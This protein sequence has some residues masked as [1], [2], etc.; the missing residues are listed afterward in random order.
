MR[1]S[2]PTTADPDRHE[3]WARRGEAQNTLYQ[4]FRDA[5]PRPASLD[6]HVVGYPVPVVEVVPPVSL[7]LGEPHDVDDG[8]H[9][10][11]VR[12]GFRHLAGLI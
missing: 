9:L 3:V 6:V 5:Q 1:R 12:D 8:V 2:R 11:L 4:E 10:G 7:V